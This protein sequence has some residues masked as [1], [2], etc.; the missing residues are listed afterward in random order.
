MASISRYTFIALLSFC[1]ISHIRA[2]GNIVQMKADAE[3][4]QNG[5]CDCASMNLNEQTCSKIRDAMPPFQVNGIFP[6]LTAT[7]SR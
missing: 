1:F 7:A 5:G 4:S 3:K 2:V 6:S